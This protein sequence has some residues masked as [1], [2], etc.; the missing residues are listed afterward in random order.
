MAF[1]AED[2]GD[3]YV[4]D[5]GDGPFRLDKAGLDEAVDLRVRSAI[6]SPVVT[7]G[8][9]APAPLPLP[10]P[11]FV[12]DFYRK[13]YQKDDEKQEQKG[14]EQDT[15][16]AGTPART[17]RV[18]Q[19][20]VVPSFTQ[21]EWNKLSPDD[22]KR[23][24]EARRLDV[25]RRDDAGLIYSDDT[26]LGMGQRDELFAG[27][28]PEARR[29]YDAERSEDLLTRP[30][31]LDPDH[32][33]ELLDLAVVDRKKPQPTVPFEKWLDN[34]TPV[35]GF[36]EGG[37]VETRPGAVIYL[38]DGED[39]AV[40]NLGRMALPPPDVVGSNAGLVGAG[41]GD[42]S[43]LDGHWRVDVPAS[44][45]TGTVSLA[46]PWAPDGSTPSD[47]DNLVVL[48]GGRGVVGGDTSTHTINAN[49]LL[50]AAESGQPGSWVAR[51]DP[52]TNAQYVKSREPA[53]TEAPPQA[54]QVVPDTGI[55]APPRP[56][57]RYEVG[58]GGSSGYSLSAPGAG[59]G[60]PEFEADPI[61]AQA[62]K[63]KEESLQRVAEVDA[64]AG[65]EL[66]KVAEAEKLVAEAAETRVRD[67]SERYL[68]AAQ[69]MAD[70]LMNA[71]VDPNRFYQ[72]LSTAGRVSAVASIIMGGLGATLQGIGRGGNQGRNVGMALLQRAVDQDIQAQKDNIENQHS[73]MR[74][75]I[76]QGHDAIDA[77]K[78]AT[79]LAMNAAAAQLKVVQAQAGADR[80]GAA[81]GGVIADAEVEAA[82]LIREG[83]SKDVETWSKKT[84]TDAQVGNYRRTIESERQAAQAAAQD[85]AEFGDAFTRLRERRATEEDYEVLYRN[86][87]DL[88]NSMIRTATG[89]GLINAK[90]DGASKIRAQL[91]DMK[92]SIDILR[93]IESYAAQANEAILG[94]RKMPLTKE[95]IQSLVV[96]DLIAK[97]K[98]AGLGAYDKGLQ[99]LLADLKVDPTD[100][101]QRKGAALERI[102]KRLEVAQ[103]QYDNLFNDNVAGP[104]GGRSSSRR[105]E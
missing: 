11:G 103:R 46:P 67:L 17:M 8:G 42:A 30:G 47:T 53:L 58:G 92:G 97:V 85:A 99:E 9:V 52:A 3:H 45:G 86:D 88:K 24:D 90:G 41:A 27:L 4:I 7:S 39:V 81:L 62:Q 84:L 34:A 5:E 32:R 1:K 74:A 91:T 19:M 72:S 65:R 36:A 60:I 31:T 96:E 38:P 82:K 63:K 76:E 13:L 87:K 25:L 43:N 77:E 35:Q 89:W 105:S 101:F 18:P 83:I 61:F 73:V 94:G 68:G 48:P 51:L 70:D 80:A 100:F 57:T 44:P 40:P 78:I 104:A 6:A 12:R 23:Y 16:D 64:W 33:K 10:M 2:R 56:L 37:V 55:G 71:K 93:E 29:Q 22:Q 15:P 69:R 21:E 49:P 59:S 28:S 20:R 54:D 14:G 95:A 26:R 50:A 102:R 98:A 66:A 75:L 79:G